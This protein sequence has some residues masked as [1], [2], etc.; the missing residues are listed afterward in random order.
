[1][2]SAEPL[3][4]QPP[5]KTRSLKEWQSRLTPSAIPVD[6]EVKAAAIH[7]LHS[8][9][10]NARNVAGIVE[11]DPVLV[12]RLVC[13]ANKTLMRTGNEIKTLPHAISLLGFPQTENILRAAAVYDREQPELTEHLRQELSVS[14]HAAQQMQGFIEYLP[15]WH[16]DEIYLAT[17][18]QRAPLWALWAQT[19]EL[20]SALFAARQLHR[21]A[22]HASREQQWLG[23]DLQSLAA[24]LSR[25]WHLPSLSQQSWQPTECGQHRQWIMLSRI[26][27]EQGKL[28]LETIPT[29]QRLVGQPAFGI[30]LANRLAD[31][32]N[33]DW[34]ARRSLR[35]LRI[36]A[37][38]SN[39]PLAKTI[40]DIHQQAASTPQ[41][42]GTQHCVHQLLGCYHRYQQPA[43]DSAAT[44]AAATSL[45]PAPASDKQS[46]AATTSQTSTASLEA[47]IAQLQ[48]Q[49]ETFTSLPGLLQQALKTLAESLQL[50][51]CSALLI[52][53]PSRELR[54]A[55]TVGCEQSPA[56]GEFHHR[57][58]RGDLFNK[59]LQKSLSL[60]VQMDNYS[61]ITALLPASFKRATATNQFFMMSIF[62]AGKPIGILYAD[63]AV[64]N[65]PLTSAQYRQFKQLCSAIGDCI[66]QR[67]QR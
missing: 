56:L 3:T 54:T 58:Q 16:E 20:M 49:P 27:P 67:A 66:S 47:L 38:C 36:V 62:A 7:K 4:A 53:G 43:S 10:G 51:R 64:S 42:A 60:H 31:A 21:G 19:P 45:E 63:C 18:L 44:L 11:R 15:R 22:S 34:Y 6:P 25:Q 50:D 17:L 29:L 30:A 52:H 33:W 13:S 9:S 23:Y 24:A 37:T 12:L 48:Q 14:L 5:P 39:Q 65:R 40:S 28:A 41:L 59:L 26:I 35:L 57:F 46:P 2:R 32:A 8:P 61:K 55:F 1:M